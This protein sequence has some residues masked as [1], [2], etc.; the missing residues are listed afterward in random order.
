MAHSSIPLTLHLE[1]EETFDCFDVS[2]FEVETE[3]LLRFLEQSKLII[4][5]HSFLVDKIT[6]EKDY[7]KWSYIDHIEG[8]LKT[9]RDTL[10]ADVKFNPQGLLK[11]IHV[12]H[13]NIKALRKG[14]TPL[15]TLEDA[16]PKRYS[17][18]DYSD[19]DD[20]DDDYY[21][22]ERYDIYY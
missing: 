4:D 9:L 14:N 22:D 17:A 19:D 11:D 2:Y 6:Q 7:R 18:D 16:S 21:E 3:K 12:M 10:K 8:V 20:D 13:D 15:V 1:I 5:S